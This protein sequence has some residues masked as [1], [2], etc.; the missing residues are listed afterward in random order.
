[1]FL[2]NDAGCIHFFYPGAWFNSFFTEIFLQMMYQVDLTS[3]LEFSFRYF[4][5]VIMDYVKLCK[6]S[7]VSYLGYLNV[8]RIF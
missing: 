5:F 6:Y 3:F 2:G 4:P 7:N 1:M 8:S